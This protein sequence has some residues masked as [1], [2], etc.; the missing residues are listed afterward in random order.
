M[1]LAIPGKLV[2][3]REVDGILTGKV[4]FGGITREA[5][6]DFLPEAEVGDYVLV[7]V[8]FAIS[9]IDEEEA[10]KTYEYLQKTGMVDEELSAMRESS[11][12]EES[13]AVEVKP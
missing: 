12:S 4:K 3:K 13:R 2:E 1:C 5:C 10:H 9:R 11:A 7:H 6:M 8:G